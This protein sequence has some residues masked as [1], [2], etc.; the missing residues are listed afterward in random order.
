MEL[1][2]EPVEMSGFKGHKPEKEAIGLLQVL[3]LT[4]ALDNGKLT[5][6]RVQI[7]DPTDGSADLN[8]VKL[9]RPFAVAVAV[10][11]A[12]DI[13]WVSSWCMDNKI[14]NS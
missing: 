10:V 12:I 5:R 14:R 7:S 4:R 9:H 6:V 11:I 8:V 2:A 1:P 13:V 3:R